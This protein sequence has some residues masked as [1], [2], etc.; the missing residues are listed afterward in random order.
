MEKFKIKPTTN[1]V[2]INTPVKSMSKNIFATPGVIKIL[3]FRIEQEEFSSRIYHSM[4]MWLNNKGY[5]GFAKQ[6]QSDSD[7]EMKHAMFAKE[8]LLDMGI[9]PTIPALQQPPQ[10]FK[11]VADIINQSYDHEIL[12]T[13]QCNDLANEALKTGDNLMYQLSLK[14]MTEQQ[15]ELGKVQTWL[16]KL[17]AFGTDKIAIKLFDNEFLD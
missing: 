5:L 10:D 2:V 17:E 12:V 8:Y 16:D 7:D 9:Q 4:S 3:N 11:D 1:T 14:Y 6:F 15:E 13:K